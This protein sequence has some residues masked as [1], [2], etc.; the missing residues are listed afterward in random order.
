MK[1]RKTNMQIDEKRAHV[2]GEAIRIGIEE[3][4]GIRR[5]GNETSW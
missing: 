5:K 1:M 3:R 4:R 2:T